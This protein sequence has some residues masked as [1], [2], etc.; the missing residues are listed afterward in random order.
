VLD[1]LLTPSLTRACLFL[2]VFTRFNRVSGFLPA[3][4]MFW[5]LSERYAAVEFKRGGCSITALYFYQKKYKF[6]L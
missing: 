3:L 4:A 1:A 2:P 5:A 6:A